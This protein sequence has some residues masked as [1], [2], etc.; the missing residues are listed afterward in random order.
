VTAS[1]GELSSAVV[2]AARAW[3]RALRAATEAGDTTS[4]WNDA[5]DRLEAAVEALDGETA[6]ESQTSPRYLTFPVVAPAYKNQRA[7]A[8]L[9]HVWD[10]Q[11]GRPLCKRV[12]PDNLLVDYALDDLDA[13][14][15]CQTCAKRD[16]RERH[17]DGLVLGPP[18]VQRVPPPSRIGASS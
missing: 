12:K 9:T 18:V 16:P 6:D 2:E 11:E 1:E 10:D 17:P 14:A 4:D 3:V 7:E 8:F 5:C 15:T 13:P